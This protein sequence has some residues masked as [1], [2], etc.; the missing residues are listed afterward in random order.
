MSNHRPLISVVMTT[1]NHEKYIGQAIASI[2]GQTFHDFELVVV[3]DGSS[4]NT[5]PEIKKF[6]DKRIVYIAQDNQGPSVAANVAIQA[7]HGQY[8]AFM[9]G[10]DV[11]YS[12]RLESQLQ[13]Y[14][15]SSS[16]ILFGHSDF[17]DDDGQLLADDSHLAVHFAREAGSREYTLRQLF[18]HGNFLHAITSFTE[19]SILIT[20]P[21][22]PLLL[23]MQ[24][25]DLWLKVLIS[26]YPVEI[27]PEKW[28]QSRIRTGNA[29]LSAPT[30]QGYV[31]TLFEYYWVLQNYLAIDS[32]S[33]FLA[34]FPELRQEYAAKLDSDTIP[35][36]MA[37]QALKCDFF[38]HFRPAYR[39]FGVHTLFNLLQRQETAEKLRNIFGFTALDFIRITGEHDISRIAELRAFRQQ[40][41]SMHQNAQQ[42]WGKWQQTNEQLIVIS[43]EK[44]RSLLMVEELQGRLQWESDKMQ[45]LQQEKMQMAESRDRALLIIE[46]LQGQLRR[47]SEQRQCLQQEKIQMAE[48]LVFIESQLANF[49]NAT[50]VKIIS[51]LRLALGRWL[52][53]GTWRRAVLRAPVRWFKKAAQGFR[54][55]FVKTICHKKWPV[56]R[57]LVSIV[58]PCGNS[59]QILALDKQTVNQA[60]DSVQ[61]YQG[62]DYLDRLAATIDSVLAQTWQ[63][64]EII[65][66]VSAVVISTS[67]SI[68][69]LQKNKTTIYRRSKRYPVANNCNYGIK[70]ARGK[71]ICCLEVGDTLAPSYLEKAL[72]YLEST[73]CDLVY[74]AIDPKQSSVEK[75]AP[76][77][78]VDFLDNIDDVGKIARV[79][80]FSKQAWKK[81]GGLADSPLGGSHFPEH[82]EFWMRLL[83][84]GYRSKLLAESLVVCRGRRDQIFAASEESLAQQWQMIRDKNRKLFTERNRNYLQHRKR[85]QYTVANPHI[86]LQR[87]PANERPNILFALPFSIIGGA[88]TV[89]L[90]TARYLKANGYNIHVLTTLAVDASYGDSSAE[91]AE[92]AGAVYHFPAF[93]ANEGEFAE[94]FLYL[95]AAKH[96]DLI[97]QVGCDVCYHLLPQIKERFGNIKVIDQLY[98]EFGHLANNRRYSE[99]IDR[100]IVANTCIRDILVHQYQEIP[101]KIAV[102]IHGVDAYEE[103][104]PDKIVVTPEV[105]NVVGVDQFVVSFFGRFSPEKAPEVLVDLAEQWRNCG[106][107]FW[108]MIGNGP[109][110][111]EISQQINQRDLQASL[112]APGFIA[113][114]KPFLR[115]SQVLLIS[116]KIEGIPIILL[117]AMAMGV[118]VVASRVG[119]IPEVITPGYNGFLCDSGD[120][121]DFSDKIGLL[122][123]DRS[124]QAEMARNAREYA[125][126]HIST[127]RR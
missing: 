69:R 112:Y 59:F 49:Q 121:A 22:N 126:A 56:G 57:P 16:R 38:E 44:D 85:Y 43:G 80:I 47:E 108:V 115:R 29:N 117:E 82:Q 84:R 39:L 27:I 40:V 124:L 68:A 19:K 123:R 37:M 64:V 74:P 99:Y 15:E 26:G 95:L 72:Y 42:A 109:L 46:E 78:V 63:D 83:G 86:N 93:L 55:R 4:D 113:D 110:Y 17:I 62:V 89:L 28:V 67:E 24:D 31:R 58:I 13:K 77:P 5:E 97:F 33:E 23:Q 116:S 10:D 2:L 90:Q 7:A 73:P 1:Y 76:P 52:P 106:D 98:N 120:I 50:S 81:C 100:H 61:D 88:N 127:W 48:S 75:M 125:L 94:F 101:E 32:V 65:V 79:A 35:F 70:K 87:P 14:R 60:I 104:N 21:C 114:I 53:K 20:S 122:Y 92:V 9:A 71:Y 3:N 34:I 54:Q 30:N 25:F 66:V 8:I 6:N 103:F 91:F 11:C 36:A 41:N 105:E 111:S 12:H 107:I 102:I 119:G 96:I 51:K 45:C 18:D 118:P